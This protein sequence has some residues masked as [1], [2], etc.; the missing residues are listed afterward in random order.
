MKRDDNFK[1]LRRMLALKR[2]EVPPPGYFEN[3]STKVISR[4]KAGEAA[5][6]ERQSAQTPWA[7]MMRFFQLFE[8]K[9]AFAG[10]F[11]SVLCLLLLGGIFFAEQPDSTPQY[12]LQPMT[13]QNVAM[14]PQFA[15]LTPVSMPPAAES[16]GIIATTNPVMSLQP[17]T[18]LFGQPNPLVQPVSFSFSPGH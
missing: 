3:F 13:Q 6:L 2:H 11:A 17:S 4:I 9:P 7:M 5:A 10:A 16:T 12:L 8:A 14:S 18:S 1:A 15:A